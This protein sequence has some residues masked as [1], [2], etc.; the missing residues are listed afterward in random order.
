[1]VGWGAGAAGLL[2]CWL[3]PP[4]HPRPLELPLEEP[5]DLESKDFIG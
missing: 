3:E 2:A 1:M 4:N 5:E